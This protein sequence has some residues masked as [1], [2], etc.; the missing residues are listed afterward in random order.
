[1]F[2]TATRWLERNAQSINLL[3][4]YPVPDGDTGIN[5]LLTMRAAM[6]EVQ[7]NFDES[8]ANVARAMA[9]GSLMG[10]RG[11]SGVIL[12]QILR[13]LAQG[14]DG[15]ESFSGNDLAAALKL[16]SDC[17]YKAVSNP[18]EGTI[19]TVVRE[20]ADAAYTKS[21]ANNTNVVAVMETVVEEARASV[22]RT[23]S[24]LAVLH[25]A[26]V[27]DAGGQGLYVIFEGALHYLRG[28]SEKTVV[29]EMESATVTGEPNQ[30]AQ[31]Q[32]GYCTE[33]LLQGNELDVES[34]R[35]KLLTMGES[36]IIVGDAS[37]IRVHLHTFDPEAV[38]RYA[39]SWGTLDQVKIDNMQTQH[40]HFIASLPQLPTTRLSTV[41]VASGEG[42]IQVLLSIGATI[43]VPGGE[44]MNPSVQELLQAVDSVP[45]RDVILLPNNPNVL[46]AADQVKELSK[47]KITVVP[48]ATIPQ[49]IAAMLTVNYDNDLKT[50]VSAMKKALST[51]QSGEITIAV[52]STNVEGL[53]IKEGQAVAFL[54]SKPISADDNISKVVHDLLDRMDIEDSELITLYHGADTDSAE[55]GE[56]AHSI[57]NKY[58]SVEVEM[59]AGGQPHYNYIISVE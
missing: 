42:L 40:E 57:R 23:P 26:G 53:H 38:L 29:S 13:G 54:D 17:A 25:Q 9:K 24:L 47:K 50:N 36:V 4:V 11:N 27:V 30:I 48:S 1:M 59:I 32:Y 18:E 14:L 15:K 34:M 2:S 8:A 12:S 28:N 3:N 33:F 51:V 58:K 6:D 52:R 16:S 5:M 56:I 41:T 35:E 49:G 31:G 39:S 20:A 55:A 10:A 43:V 45:A 19:L 44:S 21:I 37:I 22:A 7:P 46:L